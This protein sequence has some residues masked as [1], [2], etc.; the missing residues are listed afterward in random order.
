VHLQLV[1]AENAV[2]LR[3]EPAK[4]AEIA[5]G[6][7]NDGC[8]RFLI[9]NARDRERQTLFLPGDWDPAGFFDR[10]PSAAPADGTT[11]RK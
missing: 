11:G 6:N 8:D 9:G 1:D 10:N 7:A 2:D 5:A 3:Q 4:Q